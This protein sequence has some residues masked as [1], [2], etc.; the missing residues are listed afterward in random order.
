MS[1]KEITI[2][3]GPESKA[4]KGNVI[5]WA[6]KTL[7]SEASLRTEAGFILQVQGALC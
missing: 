2:C 7:G 3:G 4:L 6:V 5:C 1:H